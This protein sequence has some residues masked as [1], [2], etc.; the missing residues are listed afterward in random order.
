MNPASARFPLAAGQPACTH[1]VR[2]DAAQALHVSTRTAY[3]HVP[4]LHA[5]VAAPRAVPCAAGAG[6]A[7]STRY[8]PV[9]SLNLGTE[10]LLRLMPD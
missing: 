8:A 5:V 1:P 10:A 7:K 9:G 3:M 2:P 4:W 6:R